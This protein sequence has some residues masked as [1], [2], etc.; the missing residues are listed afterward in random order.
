MDVRRRDSIFEEKTKL[1]AILDSMGK[2]IPEGEKVYFD[3]ASNLFGVSGGGTQYL[4]KS[5]LGQSVGWFVQATARTVTFQSSSYLVGELEKIADRVTA[6]V[7]NIKSESECSPT[8]EKKDKNWLDR[9]VE[10]MREMDVKV[11]GAICGLK[12]LERTYGSEPAKY[13]DLRRQT[14]RFCDPSNI[15]KMI[16]EL[17]QWLIERQAELDRQIIG[18][19]VITQ[20]TNILNALGGRVR[21]SSGKFQVEIDAANER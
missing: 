5:I 8:I 18:V 13:N 2:D 3:P 14:Q 20:A 17:K 9:A 16:G 6:F 21:T 11:E 1:F 15:P 10:I 12:R 19:T 7:L 4:A